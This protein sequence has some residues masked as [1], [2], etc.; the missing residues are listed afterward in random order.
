[1]KQLEEKL[2]SKNK[3]TEYQIQ[4]ILYLVKTISSEASKIL[5][6]II[7]FRNQLLS[8]FLALIIMFFLRSFSGGIH[9]NTYMGCLLTT[10]L[11]FVLA[12]KLLPQMTLPFAVKVL[13][14]CLCMILS[15]R[16]PP[17]TSKYRPTLSKPKIILCQNI[18][19]T[20]TFIYIIL[21]NIFPNSHLIT[22]GFWVIILHFLQLI[23]ARILQKN[24]GGT[25][26]C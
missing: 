23:T 25:T 7:I 18:T 11:Y 10:I 5:I 2:R 15:T 12:I 20:F 21:L 6:M 1:M 14:L 9:F 4:Q 13:L 26:K 24:K 3:Y 22:V 16:I 17:V 8:Y 19:T